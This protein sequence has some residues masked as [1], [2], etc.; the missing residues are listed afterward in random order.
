MMDIV[1]AWCQKWLRQEEGEEGTIS[2]GICLDCKE[3]MLTQFHQD[4]EDGVL[5]VA[6]IN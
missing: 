5:E 4:I 2:H 3:Q 6:T 1:C